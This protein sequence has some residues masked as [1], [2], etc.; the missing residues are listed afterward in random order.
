MPEIR[1]DALDLPLI[2]AGL[3]FAR[4]AIAALEMRSDGSRGRRMAR[5]LVRSVLLV[6]VAL[7]LGQPSLVRD[8]EAPRRLV[9]LLDR[10]ARSIEGGEAAANDMV[11]RARLAADTGHFTLD[12]LAFYETIRRDA[13]PAAHPTW[14][15][16]RDRG[17]LPRS[18]RRASSCPQANPPP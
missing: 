10:A 5:T 8:H 2:T 17:S 18:V 14:A 1:F 11:S 15:Q 4:L 16:H 9:L 7:A 13:G 12:V 6:A 3:I